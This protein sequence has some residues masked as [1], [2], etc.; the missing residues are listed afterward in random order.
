MQLDQ[1]HCRLSV[2]DTVGAKEQALAVDLGELPQAS[3]QARRTHRTGAVYKGIEQLA[4]ATM[5]LF[6]VFG[7][8][9]VLHTELV[10][11]G[12]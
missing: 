12:G 4:L 8:V 11:G 1:V 9:V 7:E 5:K 6:R 2:G 3:G 10:C